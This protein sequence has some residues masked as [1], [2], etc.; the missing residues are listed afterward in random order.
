MAK[1]FVVLF[2]TLKGELV[3]PQYALSVVYAALC[4]CESHN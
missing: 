3:E 1:W 2:P 4:V